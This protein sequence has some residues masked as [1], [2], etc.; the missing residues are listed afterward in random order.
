MCNSDKK[1][2]E[3]AGPAGM[4]KEQLIIFS[5]ILCPKLRKSIDIKHSLKVTSLL[6]AF[7]TSR[8]Q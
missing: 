6:C 2:T 4:E 3:E 1:E 7:F 5:G 8:S